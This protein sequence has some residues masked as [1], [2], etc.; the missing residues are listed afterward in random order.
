VQ[1]GIGDA[2]YTECTPVQAKV[3]PLALAGRD[4][5]AQSQTG[6]GKTAAF[7]I[8]IFSRL[9]RRG[10]VDGPKPRALIIAPTRELAVQIE[11]EARHMG[12]HTGL[13][14]VA[15]F[16]G[17]DYESSAG[18]AARADLVVGTPGGSS[19][20]SSRALAHR[21]RRDAGHRRGRPD[22]RH[23]FVQDLRYILGACRTATGARRCC[24]RDAELLGHR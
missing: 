1:A 7:L 24:F 4:I 13:S 14:A 15:I 11:S 9:L 5:A 22:V 10:P 2:G 20:F 18:A 16:G 19:T 6:T 21:G 8:T 23:G 3:L 12:A 17:V